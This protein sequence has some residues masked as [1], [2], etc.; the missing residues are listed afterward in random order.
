MLLT[1][2]SLWLDLEAALDRVKFARA[3]GIQP[4]SWQADLLRS[5]SSRVLLNCSRQSGKSTMAA[6]LALHRALYH[7][8]SLVLVLAPAL[9]QSQELFAKLSEFYAALGEP[10][11]KY[12]ERRLSLELTN[13][14]RCVSLPSKEQTTRGYSGA[15]LLIL[16][17]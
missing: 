13:G 1:R 12:S 5:D 15:S 8:G 2:Q 7:P 14:S 3:L 4:D 10:M 17:E 9:R 11:R 16:D 6:V